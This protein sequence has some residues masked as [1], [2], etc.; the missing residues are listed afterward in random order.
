MEAE[1]IT[2]KDVDKTNDHKNDINKVERIKAE[3]DNFGKAEQQ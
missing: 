1:Q 2:S 3:D